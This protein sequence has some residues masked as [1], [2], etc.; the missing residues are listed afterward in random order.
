MYDHFTTVLKEGLGLGVAAGIEPVLTGSQSVVLANNIMQRSPQGESNS[1]PRFEDL[2]RSHAWGQRK[3]I[4]GL[5]SAA[6]DLRTNPL[7]RASLVCSR[8]AACLCVMVY[9]SLDHV[10]VD[11]PPRI[12]RGTQA[13]QARAVP[14][15]GCRKENKG[16][17]TLDSNQQPLQHRPMPREG[18]GNHYNGVL[19]R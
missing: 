15:R 16:S 17:A 6:F 19:C 3:K 9:T 12:E 7:A 18:T 13:L 4:K 1:P 14:T 11:P 2:G 10:Y 5:T 8:H